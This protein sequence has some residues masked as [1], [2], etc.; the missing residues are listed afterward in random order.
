MPTVRSDIVDV[1]LFREGQRGVEFLQLLRSREPMLHTWHPIMGHIEAGETAAQTAKREMHEE[2][3]L[4][5]EDA[6]LVEFFALEQVHPFYI[7]RTDT[8]V[9]SPRFAGRVEGAWTPALNHEHSAY[10]WVSIDGVD[11]S[12]VWPGQHAAIAEIRGHVLKPSPVREML[13]LK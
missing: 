1:Y 6:A 12:F 9:M 8:I 5:F 2:V 7:A 3:G 10:R 4:G 13:R 11:G